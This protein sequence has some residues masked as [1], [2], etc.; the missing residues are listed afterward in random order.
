MKNIYS[1][2]LVSWYFLSPILFIHFFVIALPSIL[3]LALCFTDWNGFGKIQFIG[4]QNFTELFD[5]RVFKIA[6]WH[7]FIW[8]IFF[9]TVPIAIALL[10]AFILTGVKRFQLVYR[11]IFFFP[12]ILASV[13]NCLIWKYL[14]HPKHGLHTFFED[15]GINFFQN[16]LLTQKETSLLAV[17]FVDAWHFWGFLVVIYITAMY[18]VD[19]TL[20]EAAEIE[21]ASKWQKFRYVT[22]PSIRPMFVFSILIIMI[23]SV[24]AFDYVY[25]L[26]GGG[27]A[28]SS[29]V[30]ANYL[31]FQAFRNMNV[32][33]A[34]AIG[35]LMFIYVFIITGIFGLLRRLE[36]EF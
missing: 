1:E 20:Y 28:Y 24:P 22:F 5:D 27:P 12:Y 6:V 2:K 32:G 14:F 30:L 34:S 19:D 15:L 7:N 33:Y 35:A 9:L 31:H 4:F 16:S 21:G 25:I 23:W 17:G 3:S 26:T 36:C 8:T 29:E 10:G 11:F 18:Q 13:V